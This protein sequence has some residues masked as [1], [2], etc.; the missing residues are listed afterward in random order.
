VL[1][2]KAPLPE[3]PNPSRES[4]GVTVLDEYLRTAFSRVKETSSYDLLRRKSHTLA[5]VE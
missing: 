1:V 2:W 3:E 5:E 4:S